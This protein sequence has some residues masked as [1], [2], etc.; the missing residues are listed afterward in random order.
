M[1]PSHEVINAFI[2]WYYHH[3]VL[4]YLCLQHCKPPVYIC[5]TNTWL[6]SLQFLGWRN[7]QDASTYCIRA[8]RFYNICIF[9]YF[10]NKTNILPCLLLKSIQFWNI[11]SLLFNTKINLNRKVL[12]THCLQI[13]SF[14]DSY[15]S[16]HLAFLGPHTMWA[17]SHLGSAD[18]LFSVQYVN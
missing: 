3:F 1:A 9:R 4:L 2:A 18:F 13:Q 16:V 17:F 6:T 12:M 5:K 14:L 7:L 15:R 8:I 11:F 10:E